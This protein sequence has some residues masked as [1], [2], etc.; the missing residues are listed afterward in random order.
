MKKYYGR[1]FSKALDKIIYDAEVYF[2]YPTQKEAP[3]LFSKEEMML[4]SEVAKI[5]YEEAKKRYAEN[6]SYPDFN[7]PNIQYW[8]EELVK[9]YFCYTELGNYWEL[10]ACGWMPMKSD[11]FFEDEYGTYLCPRTRN[12]VDKHIEKMKS[13]GEFY[14]FAYHRKA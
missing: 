9:Y 8:Y 11:P 10:G 14:D 4:Y 13:E 3:L 12:D 5:R 1:K 6:T 2:K 7:N